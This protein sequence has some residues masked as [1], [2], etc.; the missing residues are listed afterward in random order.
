MLSPRSTRNTAAPQN[1]QNVAFELKEIARLLCKD[2]F[3]FGDYL[4]G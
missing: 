2:E 3:A 1:P 4:Q